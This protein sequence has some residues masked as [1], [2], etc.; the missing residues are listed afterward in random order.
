[1]I[2]LSVNQ[3]VSEVRK[4]IHSKGQNYAIADDVARA[5]GWLCG[6]GIVP[7]QE[8][9]AYLSA[10]REE[11]ASPPNMTAQHI[12][13]TKTDGLCDIVAALDYCEA[14]D[15][16]SLS[17][18]KGRYPVITIGLMALRQSPPFGLFTSADK[19]SLPEIAAYATPEDSMSWQITDFAS[20]PATD[21]NPLLPARITID[22]QDYH[23]LK[24]WAHESYV[25]SS[26]AS[27][28]S[29]AGAGLNDND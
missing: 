14:F 22:E 6:Y 15:I 2:A 10:P 23:H 9:T 26:E 12:Q 3:I 7:S 16:K 11:A 5:T 24:Q 8:V 28:K 21:K 18:T 1:M 19:K 25:P 20:A 27:R 29:G 4:A 17:I 13:L